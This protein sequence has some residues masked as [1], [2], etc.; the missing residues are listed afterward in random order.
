MKPKLASISILLFLISLVMLLS[1]SLFEI[2]LSGLTIRV[3][4]LVSALVLLLPA[5]AGVVFGGLSL[6][7]REPKPWVAITGM[8]LNG[9]FAAFNLLV[10]AF[11]G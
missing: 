3:E 10:L 2:Y 6:R 5:C 1:V 11:A 4:R 9:A 7:R 8:A